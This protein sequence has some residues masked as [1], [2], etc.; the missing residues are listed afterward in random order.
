MSYLYL[1]QCEDFNRGAQKTDV[2]CVEL[3]DFAGE[4]KTRRRWVDNIKVGLK[5]SVRSAWT[6]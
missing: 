3:H 5:E 1:G 6:D 4:S 2:S